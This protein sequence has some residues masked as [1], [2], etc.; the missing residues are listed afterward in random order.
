MVAGASQ[1]RIPLPLWMSELFCCAGPDVLEGLGV[2]GD[3][4][5][6]HA[7]STGDCTGVPTLGTTQVRILRRS[8]HATG[9]T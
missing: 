6:E 4:V 1:G 8:G 2:G 7:S 5:T 3:R 9:R